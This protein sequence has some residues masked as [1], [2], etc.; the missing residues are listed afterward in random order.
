[1]NS[2]TSLLTGGFAK[3]YRTYIIG[4]LVALQAIAAFAVGDINMVEFMNQLPEILAGLGLMSL[5]AGV[6]TEEL[7]ETKPAKNEAKAKK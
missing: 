7:V 3:G 4:G 2:M 1:M 6:S 5:R